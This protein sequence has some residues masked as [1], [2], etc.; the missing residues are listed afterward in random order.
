LIASL[1]FLG[2]CF[3]SVISP[4]SHIDTL[5]A[6]GRVYHLAGITALMDE[7]Y[8]LFECDGF[9]LVCRQLYR[10]GDLPPRS[11]TRAALAYDAGTNTLSIEVPELG[12]IHSHRP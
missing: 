12:T 3:P 5:A 1:A 8:A 11:S 6:R 2:A 7:N 9:D 4:L 10:S